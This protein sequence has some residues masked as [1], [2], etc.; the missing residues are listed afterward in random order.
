MSDDTRGTITVHHIAEALFEPTDD[1]TL[2]VATDL[3]RGPWDP[4]HCHGGPVAAF[5][6][7]AVEAADDRDHHGEPV[8][9]QVSRLTIGLTRP[10]PVGV[11]LGLDV[12]VDRPGRKVSTVVG[13][14][15][16]DGG[17]VARVSAL[18]IREADVEL[19][20]DV[21][22]L[23]DSAEPPMPLPTSAHA[24]TA[25]WGATDG[26]PA[27]HTH[28]C[29]HRFVEGSWTEHG[30]SAVW[31][32]LVAAVVPGEEPS[33]LQRA[34]AAA[35][36]GNGVSATLPFEQYSYLNPDLTLQFAQ[37]PAGEWIGMRAASRY[38]AHG[39]GFAESALYDVE[40]TP[41]GDALARRIGRSLQSL[42]VVPR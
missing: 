7:R 10:V 22:R 29:E 1:G 9:W 12:V 40:P 35:D 34:A 32:R 17:E 25:T 30:P 16:H 27:F 18:R 21:H 4:R 2:V 36:F 28:A 33:G 8:A 11:P 20:G 19:P 13:V 6:T 5:L 3:A 39:A 26:L 38:G 37:A 15:S 31:V 41:N 42:L 14:L 24:E 23:L